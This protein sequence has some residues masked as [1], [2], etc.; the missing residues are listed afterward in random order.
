MDNEYVLSSNGELYHWGIPGMRWGVRRYQNSD[1]SLTKAGRRRYKEEN[2]KLKERERI[3]KN[4]ER[5]KARDAKL[6]AKKA[7]LDERERALDPA[8]SLAKNIKGT[9]DKKSIKDMTDAELNQAINRARLEDTYRQLYPEQTPNKGNGFGKKFLNESV[10]PALISSG[11]T[12]LQNVVTKI[13]NDLMKDK[14]DPN[15]VEALRKVEEKLKLQK[16]IKKLQSGDDAPSWDDKLKEQTYN[17]NKKKYDAEDAAEAAAASKKA[18]EERRQRQI[19][20]DAM[21]RAAANKRNGVDSDGSLKNPLAGDYDFTPTKAAVS[22]GRSFV[23]SRGDSLFTFSTETAD[24]GRTFVDS[25]GNA[26]FSWG[27]DD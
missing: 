3:I 25:H 10:M 18:A 26:L 22:N 12:I 20:I 15:S 2:D 11:K 16:S 21:S 13:G 1:G 19:N 9:S 27:D 4:K 8:R 23:D 6:A 14:V 7:E 17:R 24:R 5:I